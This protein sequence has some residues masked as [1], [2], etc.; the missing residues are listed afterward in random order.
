M[1]ELVFTESTICLVLMEGGIGPF[2]QNIFYPL[3]DII[4]NTIQMFQ[5]K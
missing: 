2:T 1:R 5:H 4:P 3:K